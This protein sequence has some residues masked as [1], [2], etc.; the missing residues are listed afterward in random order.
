[1]NTEDWIRP[2]LWAYI[3]ERDRGQREHEV[4]AD[5]PEILN[6]IIHQTSPF[7]HKGKRAHVPR[8]MEPNRRDFFVAPAVFRDPVCPPIF[9]AAINPYLPYCPRARLP[10]AVYDHVTGAVRLVLPA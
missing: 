8:A 7:D 6:Y 5:K 9:S 1:M 3:H 4:I 10:R 2:G